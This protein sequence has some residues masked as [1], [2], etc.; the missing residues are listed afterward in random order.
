MKDDEKK[1][2]KWKSCDICHL[3]Y[4]NQRHEFVT[5]P[6]RGHKDKYNDLLPTKCISFPRNMHF[7]PMIYYYVP[8]K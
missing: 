4:K 6:G 1:K 7:V 8:S 3:I 5:E 2:H